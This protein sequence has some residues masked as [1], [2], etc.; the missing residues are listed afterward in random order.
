RL[1]AAQREIAREHL[2]HHVLVAHGAPDEI[3]SDRA[4]RQLETDIAHDGRNDRAAFE[5]ALALELTRAQEQHG[6]AVHDAAVAVDEDRAVAV[7]IER[8]AELAAALDDG[9]RQ[10]LWMRGPAMQVDVAAVWPIGDDDG[11]EPEP[12]EET[13]RHGRRRAVGAVDRQRDSLERRR[14]RKDRAQMVKV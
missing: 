9:A 4:E 7:A 10:P 1:L 6:V 14:F 3:H 11:L 2:L 8:D 12:G 13:R 5:P